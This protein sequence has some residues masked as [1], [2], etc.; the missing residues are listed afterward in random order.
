MRPDC[1]VNTRLPQEIS[2]P[3]AQI[4]EPMFLPVKLT[5]GALRLRGLV[6]GLALALALDFSLES[7]EFVVGSLATAMAVASGICALGSLSDFFG[8]FIL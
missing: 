5:A 2:Q 6:V 7:E 3:R 8:L 1:D 4:L